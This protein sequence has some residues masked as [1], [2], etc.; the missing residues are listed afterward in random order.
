MH[1]FERVDSRK[2]VA[3]VFHIMGSALYSQMTRWQS[4]LR[5]IGL[6]LTVTRAMIRVLLSTDDIRKREKQR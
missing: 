3:Q 4:N 2:S 1:T 6:I 5:H